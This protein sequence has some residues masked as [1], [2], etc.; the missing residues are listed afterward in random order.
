MAQAIKIDFFYYMF[1]LPKSFKN[2]CLQILPVKIGPNQFGCPFCQRILKNSWLMNRHILVHTG[3][4]PFI[5]H[6]CE[7]SSN[8]KY[9][10]KD[11]IASK[12][13]Q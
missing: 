10:L 2:I 11:H 5:C 13:V 3:E 9:K 1:L 12:H 6:L 7:Y 8:R 4:K